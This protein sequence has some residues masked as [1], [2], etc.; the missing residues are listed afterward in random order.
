M[1]Q[2]PW[3][4]C[5]CLWIV[6]SRHIDRILAVFPEGQFLF[7]GYIVAV[8]TGRPLYL[9]FH[10]TYCENRRGLSRGFAR[11]LQRL[12]HSA[13]QS[14]FS[15][16]SRGMSELYAAALSRAAADAGLVDAIDR[17]IPDFKS[18]LPPVGSPLRLAFSGNVNASCRDAAMRFGEAIADCKDVVVSIYT[19]L[20]PRVLRELG[21]LRPGDTCDAMSHDEIPGRLAEANVSAPA[22]RLYRPRP[23]SGGVFDDLPDENDGLLDERKADSR[24]QPAR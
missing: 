21:L 7:A 1:A 8:M 20:D 13:G 11:W 9:Y 10:N 5:Q 12:A 16:S 22:A 15:S 6:W 19:G 4:M 24:P 23:R 17:P 14:M 3:L 18:G 2:F